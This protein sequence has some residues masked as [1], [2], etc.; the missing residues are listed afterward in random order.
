MQQWCGSQAAFLVFRL[1]HHG[2]FHWNKPALLGSRTHASCQLCFASRFPLSLITLF[3][4]SALLCAP[5]LLSAYSTGKIGKLYIQTF[6]H[7]HN[8]IYADTSVT[9]HTA[10]ILSLSYLA[11]A[12]K[13]LY[14]SGHKRVYAQT[15]HT[16]SQSYSGLLSF[17]AN[18]F[19]EC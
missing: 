14:S 6:T 11:P 9:H 13:E 1:M 16:N 12:R 17:L 10:T 5:T 18:L 4:L 7:T 15:Q 3:P 2:T 8:L 19:T